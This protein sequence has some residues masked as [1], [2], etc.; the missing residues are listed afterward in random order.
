MNNNQNNNI[1]NNQQEK[2][3]ELNS[4]APANPS[5]TQN[6][7][8]FAEIR[9]GMVVMKDGSFRSVIACKSINYDLMS[10]RER[11][12]VEYSYQ[13]FL[14][15]LTFPIQIL[16]RSQRVDIEP[17]LNKLSDIL[18]DQD[19]MLLSDLMEDYINFI[20]NL[21]RSANIMD[22]SFFIVVPYYPQGDLDTVKKQAKG[23]FGRLFSK[24]SA[25]ISKIDRETWEKALEEMKK[26]VDGITGGLF[27][28][29]IKSVQ[30]N[31]KELGELYY[32]AYNPDTAIYE[33][34]GDFKEVA[35]LVVRKGDN[36]MKGNN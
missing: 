15:A 27:Q 13:S 8:E 31:T 12:G 9:E 6:T 36:N 18:R 7:L 2:V 24:P 29:G 5:S 25:K 20:D 30:L 26:R 1:N 16:V 4:H 34:L 35:G 10:Q 14:N 21:S 33:P 22:K 19:N 28:I 32:N 23:F 11:E 3:P 17:Y